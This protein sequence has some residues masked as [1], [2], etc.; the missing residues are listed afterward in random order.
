MKDKNE[1]LKDKMSSGEESKRA[2]EL[3]DKINEEIDDIINE[4]IDDIENKKVAHLN[5]MFLEFNDDIWKQMTT[6][7][8]IYIFMTLA[9]MQPDPKAFMRQWLN[10]SSQEVTNAYKEALPHIFENIKNSGELPFEVDIKEYEAIFKEAFDS[11]YNNMKS[12]LQLD[13]KIDIVKSPKFN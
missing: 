7:M 6:N 12:T 3:R 4:E 8:T 2:F 5:N 10:H 13:K 11:A 1:K 9:K